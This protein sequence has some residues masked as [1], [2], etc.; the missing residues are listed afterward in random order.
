MPNV[1]RSM[2]QDQTP[3]MS[4]CPEERRMLSGCRRSATLG[5]AHDAFAVS[6]PDRRNLCD[7]TYLL[8][9]APG[10]RSMIGRSR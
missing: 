4:E 3:A 8:G 10:S 9:G 1:R 2:R 7:G 5:R 6:S